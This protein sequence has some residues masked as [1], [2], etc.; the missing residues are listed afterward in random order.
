MS[1]RESYPAGVPCWVDVTTPEPRAAV[2]FYGSLLGWEFSEPGPMPA[3]LPVE[4]VTARRDGRDVAGVGSAEVPSWNTYVRVDSAAQAAAR[5]ISVGGRVLL[6][7]T[8]GVAVIAD[9][10]GAAIALREHGGAQLVN[11]P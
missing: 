4:Y 11:E 8:D 9:P 2:D 1:Q 7:A 6:E 5:A 3:G 10:T